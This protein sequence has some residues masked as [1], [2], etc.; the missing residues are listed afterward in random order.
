MSGVETFRNGMSF[1]EKKYKFIKLL[2]ELLIEDKY[3]V[4]DVIKE[5]VDVIGKLMLW[6]TNKIQG[7]KPLN[8]LTYTN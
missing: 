5:D 7:H 1:K 6:Y 3:F 2:N 4:V 8:N